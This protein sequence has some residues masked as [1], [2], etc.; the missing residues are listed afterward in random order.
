MEPNGMAMP[1]KELIQRTGQS[2]KVRIGFACG[3]VAVAL[4]ATIPL[5]GETVTATVGLLIVSAAFVLA[6]LGFFYTCSSVRCPSCGARWLWLMASKRYGDPE[7]WNFTRDSCNVCGET[8]RSACE[9][10]P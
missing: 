4:V 2:S 10:E 8:G 1:G 6:F 7:H 9:E 5:I 3:L